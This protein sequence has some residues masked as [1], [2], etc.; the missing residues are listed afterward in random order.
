MGKEMGRNWEDWGDGNQNT[1]CEKNVF[2]I[3]PKDTK[4]RIYKNM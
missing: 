4:M 2:S 1:V 3:K